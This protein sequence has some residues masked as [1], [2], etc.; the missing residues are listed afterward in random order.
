MGNAVL[1]MVGLGT[2]GRNLL[3]N[4]ADHG[5]PVA[6][7]DKD[8]SKVEQ[9]RKETEG[10]PIHAAV[11][12]KELVEKLRVPRTVMILVPAG[13][14]VD[15]VIRDVM[16]FLS[17]GDMIIDGG[18][19]Y[20][21][22]TDLR[23]KALSERGNLYLGVGISGGEH[24]ARY[25]PSIM[26]G[27]P[28]EGYERVRAIFEAVAAQVNGQPCVAYMGPGSAG[29]YVKM[30]HNGI[31][32]AILQS[33]ADTYAL[34]KQGVG[35]E[36]G[37]LSAI[38][39]QWNRGKLNSYLLEITAEIFL[40]RDEKTHKLL[41]NVIL[42]EA[43]Q[44][45][46]GKWT[47]QDAMDLQIPT[48]T[49]DISVAMRNLSGLKDQ[50]EAGSRMLKGPSPQFEGERQPFVDQMENALYIAMVESFAQGM[51]VL[52]AA[53]V[54]CGYHLNVEEIARIWRGGCIIRA[55]MLEGIRAAFRDQPDL[56]NLMLNKEIAQALA[57]AQ[58]DL[59]SIV[60]SSSEWGIPAPAMMTSLA[61][62]DSYR[63]AWLPANLIQAQRDYFGAHTYE[64]IDE[65]GIFHTEWE[66]E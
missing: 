54:A 11:T 40:M 13:R 18:N 45:G 62:Y 21:R 20:Y 10:R 52:S 12:A 61:Y 47:S 37:E 49:I 24:G 6:G 44:L 38:Y 25:G 58:A 65:K 7:Y 26:P 50:R 27:G 43:K 5:F 53:S 2:I 46:T 32:Y 35:L 48:P 59:R 63:S 4:M 23:A 31:E 8:V 16:P 9:L 30:V 64:R 29:H 60:R 1:G 15:A 41:V 56:P 17:R 19:S 28:K 22:D 36:D 3:L 39:N 57:S 34:L 33:I 51:A 14:P 66:S 42:D 55:A